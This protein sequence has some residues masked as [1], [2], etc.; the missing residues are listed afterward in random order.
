MNKKTYIFCVTSAKVEN[1]KSGELEYDAILLE[2][3]AETLEEAKKDF[4]ET[5]KD[6]I[7]EL[8]SDWDIRIL[9][10]E[11]EYVIKQ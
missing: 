2:T 6:M 10:I 8:F 1:Y 7:E 3:K 5:C 9:E 4:F 11:N